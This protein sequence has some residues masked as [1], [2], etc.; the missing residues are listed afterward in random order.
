MHQDF[1]DWYRAVKIDPKGEVLRLRWAGVDAFYESTDERDLVHLT[2]LFFQLEPADRSFLDRFRAAFKAADETFPMK[3]NDAEMSVLAGAELVN[4]FESE[5]DSVSVLAV[6]SASGLS[7]R[8][9]PVAAIVELALAQLRVLSLREQ[10]DLGPS[11]AMS[12]MTDHLKELNSALESNQVSTSSTALA[13]IFAEIVAA[14]RRLV[15]WADKIAKEQSRRKEE[16]DILW[17]LT[18]G[19][20]RLGV[21][22]TALKSPAACLIAP[23]DLAELVE[24]APGPFAAEA[25]LHNVIAKA[26]PKLKLDERISLSK[27]LAALTQSDVANLLGTASP[28]PLLL[29]LCPVHLALSKFRE[30]AGEKAWQVTFQTATK[31]HPDN[32]EYQPCELALQFFREKMLLQKLRKV[33]TG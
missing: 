8:E 1:A 31:V 12:S 17:W 18:G 14:N 21:P 15:N 33:K 30:V 10:P 24:D 19:H 7:C 25:F 11:V 28:D 22:F 9:A 29:E 23:F 26:H 3:G 27:V 16:S 4:H 13:K 32:A 5:F 6:V 20:T 2:R